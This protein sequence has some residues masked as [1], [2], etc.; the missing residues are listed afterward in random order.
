MRPGIAMKLGEKVRRGFPCTRRVRFSD[1]ITS[2]DLPPSSDRLRG[3]VP[4]R[5]MQT[6]R[7]TSPEP[8]CS[9]RQVCFGNNTIKSPPLKLV[10]SLLEQFEVRFAPNTVRNQKYN[11]FTFLPRAMQ[12]FFNLYFILVTLSQLV[13]ALKIGLYS[14]TRFT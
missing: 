5:Y 6:T 10:Y 1:R 3:R 9:D 12:V 8:F 2:F 14:S 4:P 7:K 11:A 13:P